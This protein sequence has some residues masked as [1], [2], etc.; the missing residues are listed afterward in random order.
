MLFCY[1]PA[2]AFVAILVLFKIFYHYDEEEKVVLEE[3]ARRK[4]EKK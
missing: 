1:I 3:L 4:Q 2:I